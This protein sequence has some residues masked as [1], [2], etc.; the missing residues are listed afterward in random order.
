MTDLVTLVGV[1]GVGSVTLM[2]IIV[3]AMVGYAAL[4][5]THRT[6]PESLESAEFTDYGTDD[7]AGQ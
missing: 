5:G 6:D 4:D 3:L 7:T 2:V 1:I